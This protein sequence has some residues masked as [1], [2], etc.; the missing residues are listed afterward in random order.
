[1][2]E[3]FP[4]RFVLKVICFLSIRWVEVKFISVVVFYYLND[5][6]EMPLWSKC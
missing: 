1:M 5:I 6:E 3:V 4:F 2:F